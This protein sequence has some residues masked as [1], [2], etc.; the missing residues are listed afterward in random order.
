M[1]RCVFFGLFWVM[2]CIGKME[3][4]GGECNG[5]RMIKVGNF[6]LG[7]DVFFM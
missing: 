4:D 5:L 7:F 3:E 2:E 1:V 6:E